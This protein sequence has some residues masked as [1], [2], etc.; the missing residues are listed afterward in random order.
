MQIIVKDYLNTMLYPACWQSYFGSPSAED[1]PLNWLDNCHREGQ[2]AIPEV[3][4]GAAFRFGH[5]MVRRDYFLNQS[6]GR[7]TLP[8]LFMC[9][10]KGRLE[11]H[12]HLPHHRVID[13]SRFF[14]PHAQGAR[15]IRPSSIITIPHMNWPNNNLSVITLLRGK[16]LGLPDAF[17][18]F[19]QI[20]PKLGE[21]QRFWFRKIPP[22]KLL[23]PG[24]ENF[25]TI[26]GLR[27]ILE[28]PPLWYYTLREVK[29][30]GKRKSLG[31]LASVVIAE[32]FA[33]LLKRKQA[34][35]ESYPREL[36]TPVQSMQ[37]LINFVDQYG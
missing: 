11:G 23:D 20:A 29:R 13:W 25:K 8:E 17:T 4:N 3:F 2:K 18:L 5:A 19:D 31:P 7:V 34:T 36:T 30:F 12:E 27:Q 37:A 32:T 16:E 24:F 22:S 1:Y 26:P 15:V 14:G 21:S 35:F 9:T 28:H 33:M 6:S 10:G